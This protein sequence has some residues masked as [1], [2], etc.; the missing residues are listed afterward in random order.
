MQFPLTILMHIDSIIQF[1]LAAVNKRKI[2]APR[3]DK[4]NVHRRSFDP[5]IEK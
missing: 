3:L 1:I 5:Q 2:I 4:K